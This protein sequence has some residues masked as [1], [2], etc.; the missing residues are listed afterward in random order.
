MF[1]RTLTGK[2]RDEFEATI[3]ARKSGGKINIRGL[4]VLLV[5]MCV[6]DAD[7][8]L[9]FGLADA[10]ELNKK[11]AKAIDRLF[12]AATALNK[13]TDEAVD[14]LAGNS[15]SEPSGDSGSN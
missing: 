8:K 4:K 13:L 5:V 9:L 7:G 6:C 12:D 3:E 15:S 14:E 11:S 10:E 1:V 2:Q